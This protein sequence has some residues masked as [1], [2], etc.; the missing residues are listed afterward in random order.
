[1]SPL[2]VIALAASS[3]L[4]VDALAGVFSL[5][6]GDVSDVGEET[7]GMGRWLIANDDGDTNEVDADE[8]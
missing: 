4:T 1:M 7:K 2:M 5:A 6:A 8:R 3:N